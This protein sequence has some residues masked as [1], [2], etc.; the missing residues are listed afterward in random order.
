MKYYF[1]IID[2]II[3]IAIFVLILFIL[4]FIIN[5][6]KEQIKQTEILEKLLVKLLEKK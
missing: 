1:L 5:I 4:R 3:I 2:S 6:H